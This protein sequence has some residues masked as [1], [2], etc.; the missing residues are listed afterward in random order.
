MIKLILS[1][2]LI[3][4]LSVQVKAQTDRNY[5]LAIQWIRMQEYDKAKDMLLDLVKKEPSNQA[6]LKQ[7]VECYIQTKEYKNGIEL[8][9]NPA[10]KV[11]KDPQ[12]DND[13]ANLYHLQGD[14]AKAFVIW[15]TIVKE[16]SRN[17]MMYQVVAN[18]LMER[19]EFKKAATVYKEARL[20]LKNA[21]LY[22]NE[23]AS[24]YLQAS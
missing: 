1:F 22:L 5:V 24:A 15:D 6:Y 14:T 9:L 11:S 13:L 23:L 18:T 12:F 19:R 7:L 21:F 3:L 2:F 17:M 4:F 20:H 10:S 16:N 8:L